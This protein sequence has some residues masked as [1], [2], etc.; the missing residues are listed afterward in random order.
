MRRIGMT[1]RS[2]SRRLTAATL[3]TLAAMTLSLAA[4]G[5]NGDDAP[6]PTSA[7]PTLA[8]GAYLTSVQGDSATVGLTLIN[9][10]GQGFVLLSD[11][12]DAAATVMHISN[13]TE[14]RRAPAGPGFVTLSYARSESLSLMTLSGAALAGDYQLL[15][16]GKP[17]AV[18][19]AA[20]GHITA[21]TS[22]S[23]K[24]SG[25]I[26]LASSYGGGKGVSLNLESCGAQAAGTYSGVLYL[27]A[28]TA[29]AR[30]QA[31]VENG[32]NVIDLLA[33]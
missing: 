29:P 1:A 31:V 24:L 8:T 32:K 30:W 3:A 2:T 16:D 4:C 15:L 27:A 18:T 11:D 6:P 28:S 33:Y 21:L 23:C 9:A 10:A 7:V 14:A 12:G 20:D 25:Q 22:S 26:D 13:G 17:A 5:G 19:V